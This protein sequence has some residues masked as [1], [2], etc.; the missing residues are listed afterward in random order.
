MACLRLALSSPSLVRIS[1]ANRPW[2]SSLLTPGPSLPTFPSASQVGRYHSLYSLSEK[3]PSCLHVT[4]RTSD[5]VIMGIQH[6]SLPIAA[7]QFHP[8][9]ILTRS[10]LGLKMLVN[11]A[12]KLKY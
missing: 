9:S 12:T 7:V 11:A 5:G 6:A 3:H 8:E 10:D 4:A 1:R 2:L